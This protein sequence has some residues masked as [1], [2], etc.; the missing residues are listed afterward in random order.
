MAIIFYQYPKCGTCRKAR[1]FLED[2]EIEHES[3][4][5]VDHAPS[6]DE[7]A[8]LHRRSGLPIRKFFN[9]SG[10]LYRDGGYRE[11]IG[12]MS[13]EQAIAVLAAQGMLIR[14]P[15]LDTG[16]QVLVG[17]RPDDWEE[18]LQKL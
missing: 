13:D 4:H 15:L 11:R 5:I 16:E 14:R 6:A 10:R 9:T 1:R 3:R 12:E 8:D 18:A 7:L 17:F 2:H